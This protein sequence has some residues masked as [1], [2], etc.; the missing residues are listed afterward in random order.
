MTAALL[1]FGISAIAGAA[2]LSTL[3]WRRFANDPPG[4]WER[5]ASIAVLACAVSIAVSWSLSWAGLLDRGPLAIAAI[6]IIVPSAV[7]LFRHRP[8]ITAEIAVPWRMLF[9]APVA[10]WIVFA[11]WRGSVVPVLSHDALA[12]HMPKAVMIERAHQYEYFPAPDPR[13]STSPANYEMLLADVLLLTGKDDL[14]EWI[15]TFSLVALLLVGAA[16]AERFWGN[17]PAVL[18]TILLVTAVPVILL[19][20]GAHKNDLMANA[21]YLAA[22]LWLGRWFVTQES[23]PLLLGL[24]SLA[25]A[26]GTKLQAAFP[27]AGLIAVFGYLLFRRHIRVTRT[28]LAILTACIAAG[29]LLFGGAIYFI[30]LLHTGQV[31]LPASSSSDA[32]Y[33][34]WRNLWEV[35]LIILLRPFDAGKLDVFIPWRGE[36]WYWPHMELYFS[37]Y[38]SLVTMLVLALPLAIWHYRRRL[39]TERMQRERV[40][41]SIAALIA[42]LLM[43]PIRIRPVGFFNGFPRYF[44]FVPIFVLLWTIAPLLQDLLARGK[45]VIVNLILLTAAVV[46]ATT[47]YAYAL[48]DAFQPLD[49]VLHVADNPGRRQPYFAV[50]R[51]ATVADLAAGPTDTIAIH[52][53]FDSWIYPAYGAT[54]ERKVIFINAGDP[55]PPDVQHVVIDR[56]W[57]LIWG[58]PRFHD[59]GQYQQYLTRGKVSGEDVAVFNALSRQPDRWE[60]VY[61]VA[62][63]NQAIFKRRDAGPP[64][65]PPA[66]PNVGSSH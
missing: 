61:Y 13:I 9:L 19:H 59:M 8:A 35:P 49:Y 44:C 41:T 58:D 45:R 64:P 40:L 63:R 23:A 4:P 53:G 18:I 60:L 12:Y 66:G 29:A 22:F 37:D 6:F 1:L 47:A 2:A 30:N 43:L 3:L 51:A 50:Y 33:G 34:D 54:L 15:G 14:T 55:I 26:G 20:A 39:G 62:A 5:A 24:I 25:V 56:A 38:G 10:L 11:L 57:N 16:M 17:G 65:T 21:L 52:G 48:D 46:V 28:Q 32:G 36:R 7:Y 27:A 31:A 42:F